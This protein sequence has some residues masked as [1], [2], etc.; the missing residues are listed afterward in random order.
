MNPTTSA[1]TAVEAAGAA[2]GPRRTVRRRTMRAACTVAKETIRYEERPVPVPAPD[3]ALVRVETVT[4]CGTDLHIW[5]DDYATELPMVQGHEFCGVIEE[6]PA[7]H[8]GL[9]VGDRVAVSPIL[10]CGSCHAC[11]IG[12]TNACDRMSVY[13]CYDVPGALTELMAIPVAKLFPAPKALPARLASLCEPTSIAMQA[14]NRARPVAGEQALVLGSGPIGLLCTLYLTSLG[15]EVVAA[16]TVPERCAFAREFGAVDTVLIDTAAPFPEPHQAELLTTWTG[17]H[18]PSLV[19]EATGVPSSLNNAL[20]AVATAGRVV[21]VGISDREVTF[22][23]RTVPVKDI[24]L[25][26]SRNSQE[27]IGEAA[28]LLSRH[29]RQA[30]S[31]ITHRFPFDQAGAAFETMRSRTELVGKVAIDMPGAAS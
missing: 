17:G 22:S 5:E 10:A 7:P 24:D 15:V 14:V 23:M 11:S 21:A 2:A 16:D 18:G 6:L 8:P 28:E 13:G 9:A 25:I 1:A 30:A 26:G 3:Q 27:L 19:F 31:L 4:L 20:R 12:R 29:T